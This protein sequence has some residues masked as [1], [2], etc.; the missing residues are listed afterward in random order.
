MIL[1]HTSHQVLC[2]GLNV[3]YRQIQDNL[4]GYKAY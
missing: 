1:K 2:E 3:H 4:E